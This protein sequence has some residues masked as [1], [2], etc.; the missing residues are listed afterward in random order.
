MSD[1]LGF[2]PGDIVLDRDI[3]EG[4]PA[5]VTALPDATAEEWV[6]EDEDEGEEI[7]VAE[8]NPDYTADARV[9]VVVHTPDVHY[10][11]PDWDRYTP[12]SPSELEEAD[13][14]YYAFP[15]PRLIRDKK[16]PCAPENQ[17]ARAERESDGLKESNDDQSS[18]PTLTDIQHVGENRAED[19]R[20]AGYES[21]GD[22]ATADNSAVAEIDGIGET[23]AAQLTASA[24]DVLDDQPD[25][26][27]PAAPVETGTD[28][29]E[30]REPSEADTDFSAAIVALSRFL[31]RDG[32][33]ATVADDGQSVCV[34]TRDDSYRVSLDGVEGDGPHRSHLEEAVE[35]IRAATQQTNS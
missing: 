20:A 4:S 32:M 18:T 28:T 16:R 12:L 9:V 3:D 19:L 21:V 22:M 2:S 5:Y 8:D 1:E 26:S 13:A 29:P 31:G 14:L 35:K 17:R 11:L 15:A 7:T 33:E 25:G 34:T 30:S 23:R 10:A 6:Y 27:E 24:S